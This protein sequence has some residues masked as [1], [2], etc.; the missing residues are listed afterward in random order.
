MDGWMDGWMDG[1]LFNFYDNKKP[2]DRL[3]ILGSK[4]GLKTVDM[5]R[6]FLTYGTFK[7]ALST[8]KEK[9]YQIFVFHAEFMETWEIFL[10]FI[11][12]YATTNFKK[13]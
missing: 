11:V 7:S 4:C 13:Y 6:I 12:N 2:G 1:S 9:L 5:S 3:I 10:C 8:V